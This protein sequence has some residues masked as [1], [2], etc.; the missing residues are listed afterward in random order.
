MRQHL[1]NAFY[2]TL[3]YATYLV[4]MLLLVPTLLHHLGSTQYGAWVVS[5]VAINVGSIIASSFGDANIQLLATMHSKNQRDDLVVVTIT[6]LGI[7]LLLGVTVASLLWMFVPL[8]ANHVA[9]DNCELQTT[10]FWSLRFASLLILIRAMESVCVSTRRVFGR[11][12]AA[13]RVSI[14]ARMLALAATVAL[15]LLNCELIS[16]MFTMA[17][18]VGLGSVAQ[19][20]QIRHSLYGVTL[21]PHTNTKKLRALF[22][23][24][25]FNWLQAVAGVLFSQADRLILGVSLGATAVTVYVFCLRLVQPTYGLKAAG[26]HFLFPYLSGLYATSENPDEIRKPVSL[27]LGLYIGITFLATAFA[28]LYGRRLLGLW[29]GSRIA[30]SS[31]LM[32][33]PIVGSSALLGLSVTAYYA[34]LALGNVQIFTWSNLFGGGIMLTF[35]CFLLKWGPS[36]V[37]CSRLAYGAIA[38]VM[39]YPLAKLFYLSTCSKVTPTTV[40]AQIGEA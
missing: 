8:V 7:N 10:C 11:Y 13:V 30:I 23:F 17:C 1:A 35:M 9:P 32:L 27:A 6:I 19:L 20:L 12:G 16:I 24:G 40:D 22:A 5:M 21:L 36:G 33:K 39:Y 2:G 31:D 34:L 15:A 3:D 38:L 29:W 14:V 28:L 4:M 26:L 37:A 25:P 18:F